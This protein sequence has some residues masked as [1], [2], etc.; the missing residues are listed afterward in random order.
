MYLVEIGGNDL[1]GITIGY[2]WTCSFSAFVNGRV[3]CIDEDRTGPREGKH[4]VLLLSI[5]GRE[6][7]SRRDGVWE[8]GGRVVRL[9]GSLCLDG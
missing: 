4:L 6:A 8:V 1:Q 3:S 5:F 7:A 2:N 9:L